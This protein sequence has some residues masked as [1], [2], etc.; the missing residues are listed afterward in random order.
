MGS[1]VST[2]LRVALWSIAV[3][4]GAGAVGVAG[5]IQV[6]PEVLSILWLPSLVV[7]AIAAAAAAAVG[8]AFPWP[9]RDPREPAEPEPLLGRVSAPD[10]EAHPYVLAVRQ[11]E[12]RA[13]AST[14]A[15]NIAAKVATDGI[16]DGHRPRPLC[17]L[18][19]GEL[20]KALGLES[21]PL[22]SYFTERPVSPDEDVLGL[23]VRHPTGC[24][25]LCMGPGAPNG[26][27][28]R[29]LMPI[30][31]RYYDP[32]VIDCRSDDRWLT[33]VAVDACDV[34]LLVGLPTR[35]SVVAAARWADAGWE[36]GI[37]GQMAEVTNRVRAGPGSLAGLGSGLQHHALIPEDPLV[38]SS[39]V[40]GLP[41]I[42]D[43]DSRAAAAA[44]D[45]VER[46]LPRMMAAREAE[47]AA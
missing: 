22:R 10:R 7:A 40:N 38:V 34:L 36:R 23:A 43:F 2:V 11:L 15:F 41:W 47:H 19:E 28:L 4:G 13:G 1:N 9:S 31:R 29:L 8:V 30:L 42:L 16:L 18:S 6:V 3:L 37:T 12:P 17:L 5:R 24:E 20:A 33:E 26:Q 44:S 32:I 46:L 14:L 21:E 25:L 35:D 39:D 27:Q 45:L